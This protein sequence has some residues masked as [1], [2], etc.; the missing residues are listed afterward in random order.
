[1]VSNDETV[2]L[3]LTDQHP[4]VGE[5]LA[6][7]ELNWTPA[8]YQTA[9]EVL[10][11][12]GLVVRGQG[13]GGPIKRAGNGPLVGQNTAVPSRSSGSDTQWTRRTAPVTEPVCIAPPPIPEEAK[14]Y[15]ADLLA[16]GVDPE[17]H[18]AI[19]C[20]EGPMLIIAGPGSGKTRTL[21]E[22]VV[23]LLK[24]KK[25]EAANIMVA[26]FSEKA[27]AE[28][29]TRISNRILEL[30]LKVNLNEMYIGT[31]HSIFLRMLEENREFS[32]LNR[33]YR[34]LDRF[35]QNYMVMDELNRFEKIEDL[36]HITGFGQ[37]TRWK[38]AE[39][40]VK[41]VSKVGEEVLDLRKMLRADDPGVTALAQAYELYR[42]LLDDNDALDFSHIQVALW[43]MFQKH[44]QVLSKI[45]NQVRYILVDEYQDTNTV[46]EL[47]L[48][49]LAGEHKNIC[50]VGD[51]DQG[52]YR[53]RG[54]TI[55]NILEF[56]A[57]FES[58][59]QVTLTTNYRS[60]PDI[61]HFYNGW[62]QDTDWTDGDRMF[63]YAKRIQ[64]EPNKVFE[65]RAAVVR[66]STAHA[67]GD[68]AWYDAVHR[69]IKE[70][71][72][73]GAI[74]DR[75]Q[76]AFLFKS[77]K[78]DQALGLANYLEEKGIN[79]F[80]PR[81][82]L[83]FE[84]EEV[85]LMIGALVFCFRNLSEVLQWD[86]KIT[87]DVWAY[88]EDC[89]KLFADRLRAEPERHKELVAFCQR[90][91]KRHLEMT[92]STNYAFSGLLYQ[93]LRYDMFRPY[94]GKD[95]G[96]GPTELRS[97]YNVGR[98][99]QILTKFE[100]LH[101]ITVFT[102]KQL[103]WTLTKFFNTYLRFLIDGGIEEF[104]DFDDKAPSGCVSFM[105]I[106]QSKGL[107][108]PVVVV[109]SMNA[110]PRISHTALDE[111][112]QMGHYRKQ[113]FE[114]LDRTK[115]F[116]FWRLYYTAF[117]RPQNLLVLTGQERDGHGRTPSKYLEH[118]YFGVPQWT[119]ERFRWADVTLE[120]V[121]P[122]NLKKQYSFTSHIALYE[123]CPLQYKFYR[124]LEFAAV[125]N[126]APLFGTLVHQTI[127]DIHKAVLRGEP[128]KVS[129]DQVDRWFHHN[130]ESLAHSQRTY[131][132]PGQ[133][134][135]ARQHVQ[136]YRDRNEHQWDKVVEAEVDVSLVKEAYILQ[137]TVDLIKGEGDTVEIVDFKSEKKPDV[138]DPANKERLHRYKRQ[139]EA[140]AHIVEERTGRNV[141]RMHLYYTGEPSGNP[142]ISFTK[143][144]GN[145]ET[146]IREFDAVV[147]RIQAKDFSMEGVQVSKKLCAECD[148]RHYCKKV[149]ANN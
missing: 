80:S 71:E 52:L 35:D 48:L 49:K 111:A 126:A 129:A 73:K 83:F 95:M 96:A 62:M 137:G 60:H 7:R 81:S 11:Q 51:D 27:A 105:T 97:A 90:A 55:R 30:G 34:L 133:V 26:T 147:E 115:T 99:T 43:E 139:L 47:L 13:R 41:Y 74:T 31:L 53:F 20:T 2:L 87:L 40:L 106:H 91:A 113:P 101:T 84:R 25:L 63:R 116:D 120:E 6:C 15:A 103:T 78:G 38:K 122:T 72:A 23:Y 85:Q 94:L 1:M 134:E 18:P 17:K 89:K 119:D 98:M 12:Q 22:R 138:N 57:N 58:C 59:A 9:K 107:E 14:A 64:P 100:Y 86:P 76:V 117:S 93:L 127:E 104:E 121:K 16:R 124:E 44:P 54:A 67:A 136:R 128:D 10:L 109:G 108:F 70:G 3:A 45:Q 66:V 33:N 145:I 112:L 114:P 143:D 142:N 148:M 19:L 92:E 39:Q 131:L 144:H 141:S 135:A 42:Q 82:A 130:Y 69:F 79:V 5:G 123:N 132:A 8:R 140:Y 88:Y 24:E 46:Q 61:I 28:L 68:E 149:D 75:N 65:D 32:T 37:M 50:V 36:G 77:V 110:V 29:I 118:A 102:P 4:S 21:V 146:T 56:T 125:R